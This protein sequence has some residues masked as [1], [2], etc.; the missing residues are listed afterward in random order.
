M[1][2]EHQ[3]DIFIVGDAHQRIY[4]NHATLSSCGINIRGRSSILKINYRTTEEIRKY[5]FALLNGISFDDLDDS[6]DDSGRC[7]SLTHGDKPDIREFKDAS[8]E[9]AFIDGEI[10]R[11]QD[12][13]VSL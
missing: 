9:L 7:Q 3:N 6:T 1:G 11:L 10:K 5:A 13:G 4:E 8:E 12:S 2:E